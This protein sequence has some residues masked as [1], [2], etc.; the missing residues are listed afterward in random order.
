MQELIDLRINV[1]AWLILGA[2]TALPGPAAKEG[3]VA[4]SQPIV[5]ANSF[6]SRFS[7]I[8]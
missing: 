2:A 4:G 7:G 8:K 3:L 6:E 5:Q 1:E